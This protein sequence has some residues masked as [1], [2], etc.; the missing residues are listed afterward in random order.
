MGVQIDHAEDA[1]VRAGVLHLHETLHGAEIVAEREAP[2]RLNPGKDPEGKG[3]VGHRGAPSE[4]LAI[5]AASLTHAPAGRQGSPDCPRQRPPGALA[6]RH[7]GGPNAAPRRVPARSPLPAQWWSRCSLY[8][9]GGSR[10]LLRPRRRPPG[11]VGRPLR[12]RC[13]D[14][15]GVSASL[16]AE[17]LARGSGAWTFRAQTRCIAPVRLPPF[18]QASFHAGALRPVVFLLGARKA[19]G[20][21][22]GARSRSSGGSSSARQSAGRLFYALVLGGGSFPVIGGFSRPST[23]LIGDTRLILVSRSVR[24]GQNQLSGAF[25]LIGLLL[26]CAAL[27]S[28]C[29]FGGSA[30]DW[31]AAFW[32]GFLTRASCFS[33]LAAPGAVRA[34]P[35]PH[36]ARVAAPRR[37]QPAWLR[38]RPQRA[39]RRRRGDPKRAKGPPSTSP[40]SP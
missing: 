10:R 24:A 3:G 32:R 35:A 8:H 4:V 33:I 5:G 27:C 25:T 36:P 19:G 30:D 28:G 12:R 22:D 15:G 23:G 21:G 40:A 20:R 37:P 31:V 34:D 7:R 16:P 38:T 13:A 26:L 17:L 2:R 18:V 9:R 11:I 14:R 29:C 6:R 1:L 39:G